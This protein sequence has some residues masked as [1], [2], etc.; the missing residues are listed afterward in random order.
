MRAPFGGLLRHVLDLARGQAARGHQVGLIADSNMR[1]G[2]AEAALANLAPQ[3][4]LGINRCAMAR[5]LS[6]TDFGAVARVSRLIAQIEPDV[7]HGHGAKGGAYARLAR[8]APPAIRAYTP[9]GGSLVYGP[10]TLRGSFYRM[11]EW[12]LNW[13]TDV[14]LFESSYVGDMY[15]TAV[16]KPRGIVRIVHN[17]VSDVEF[18]PAIPEPDATDIVFVGELRAVKGIDVLIEA[19]AM[20]RQS[21]RHVS[22][23]FAGDGPEA[24]AIKAHA[25]GCG[26]HGQVRFVGHRPARQAFA[27]GRILV[28]PS[29]AESLPYIVLEAAAA[30]MP[31]VA[32]RV[33]GIPE[34]FGP[35]AA[36]HLIPSE[37]HV[38]LARAIAAAL[39]NPPAIQSVARIVQKRV[40]SE[41]S[42][43]AMV[44][45]ALAGYRTALAH[46]P[47]AS[48]A[49]Q[50]LKYVH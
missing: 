35:R 11:L 26:L 19:L 40:R 3:L 16:G 23:S 7:L 48:T 13:R 12:V 24:A 6:P 28:V 30:G 45:G 29:R 49:N 42:L 38:A 46:G 8:A 14:L 21:G 20:L 39:D 10:H 15:R 43:D 50:S 33:G 37:D 44:E 4:A 5:E 41:F 27:M 9:H 31:I 22:A 2:N 17:G 47:P 18:A 25:D 34:I 36:A 32:T 1:H